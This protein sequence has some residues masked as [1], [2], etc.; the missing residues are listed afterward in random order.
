MIRTADAAK[1]RLVVGSSGSVNVD[2][3]LR[4]VANRFNEL[5]RR[6]IVVTAVRVLG[7]VWH[8]SVSS[9]KRRGCRKTAQQRQAQ[10]GHV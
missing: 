7:V 8:S 5:G 2:E 3:L 10:D 4:G 9:E 1:E 6:S